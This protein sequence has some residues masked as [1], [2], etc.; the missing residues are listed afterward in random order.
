MFGLSGRRRP[1][2]CVNDVGMN[3]QKTETCLNKAG[4]G[5][6]SFHEESIFGKAGSNNGK[7]ARE[8]G[9]AGTSPL[10]PQCGSPRVWKDGI[11]DTDLG[12]LQRWICRNCGRR[13]SDPEVLK[14]IQAKVHSI[15]KGGRV[16]AESNSSGMSEH[17]QR[18]STN[19]LKSSPNILY[20]RQICVRRA[21]NLAV[22]ENKP[23]MGTSPQQPEIIK[24]KL[25]EYAFY[26]QKQGY[27]KDTISGSC[28]ALRILLRRNANLL[29]P[30]SVKEI[31]AKEA[32]AK[33]PIWGPNRRRNIITAYTLFVKINGLQ[34][35]K[36]KCKVTRKFPFI[37]TEQEIDGLIAGSGKKNAAFCQ[38]LKETAMRPGEAKRLQWINIDSERNIITLNDPEKGSNPRM[39]KVSQKLISMINALPKTSEQIFLG[40]LKSMKTTFIKTRKRLAANLQNPRLHKITFYTFRHWK[41]TTLYHQTKDIYYIQRFLGHKDIR[42]TIIY[43]NIEYSIFGTG[44]N[45]EFI[46]RVTEKPE[47]IKGFLQVGFEYVCQKDNLVFLRKRK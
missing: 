41:A 34:W 36:P 33:Q 46:V 25:L 10:C 38:L 18:L 30:E 4:W 17:L 40:S 5:M 24:G 15:Y 20:D 47:E 32:L 8:E 28:G 29:D 35:E 43:I 3:G 27:A 42:N 44:D 21:K 19:L 13:F 37:P 16:S 1:C 12:P 31:L 45:D 14:E 26:M 11:R 39:W 7:S 23:T 22:V 2:P 9:A 6:A